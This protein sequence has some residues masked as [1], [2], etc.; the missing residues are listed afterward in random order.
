M[1]PSQPLI[2]AQ[3]EMALKM[4]QSVMKLEFS[5]SQSS[6]FQAK[7]MD[8]CLESNFAVLINYN[9]LYGKIQCH[10]QIEEQISSQTTSE[11]SREGRWLAGQ[12]PHFTG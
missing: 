4:P 3:Q 12:T 2:L 10:Q 6:C 8:F 9:I 7:G 5:P 11:G 1:L